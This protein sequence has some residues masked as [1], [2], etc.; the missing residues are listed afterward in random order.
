MASCRKHRGEELRKFATLA[1][2]NA[3]FEYRVPGIVG[4]PPSGA[5][6]VG[7]IVLDASDSNANAWANFYQF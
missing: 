1:E 2:K 7:P 4:Q 6:V 5:N 3:G